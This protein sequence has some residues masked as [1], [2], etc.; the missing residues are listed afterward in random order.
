MVIL[1]DLVVEQEETEI[2][3][4]VELEVA[5]LHQQSQDQHLLHRMDMEMMVVDPLPPPAEEVEVALVKLVKQDNLLVLMVE[6]D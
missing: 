6:V 1:V 4:M 3:Q 2:P 5:I